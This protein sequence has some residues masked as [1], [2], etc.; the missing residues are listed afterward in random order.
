MKLTVQRAAMATPATAPLSPSSPDGTSI[1][2]TGRARA[3]TALIA[4]A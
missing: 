3:F 2:S 4:S 1:A